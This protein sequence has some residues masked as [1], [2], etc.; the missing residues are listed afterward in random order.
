MEATVYD[1]TEPSGWDGFSAEWDPA[2]P[3]FYL[4]G[5]LQWSS[6]G[7]L[8]SIYTYRL[9]PRLHHIH[10]QIYTDG[11]NRFPNPICPSNVPSPQTKY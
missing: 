3:E 11:E 10:R 2:Q 5:K 6:G 8:R 7:K 9:R 4:A 1:T